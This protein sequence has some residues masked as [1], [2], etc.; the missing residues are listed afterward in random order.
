MLKALKPAQLTARHTK[1]ALEGDEADED[2]PDAFLDE[3]LAEQVDVPVP[4]SQ[5]CWTVCNGF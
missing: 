4:V 1:E 5:L 3:V 2:A